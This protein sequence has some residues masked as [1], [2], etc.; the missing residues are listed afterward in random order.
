MFIKHPAQLQI[1]AESLL[2]ELLKHAKKK[3]TCR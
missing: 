3:E 2:I 1:K